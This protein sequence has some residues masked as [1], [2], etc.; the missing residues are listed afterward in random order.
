MSTNRT[1]HVRIRVK[2]NIHGFYASH[3]ELLSTYRD[4]MTIQQAEQIKDELTQLGVYRG[5]LSNGV[6]LF[7]TGN[8]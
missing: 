2:G 7:V 4:V 6:Q 5:D 8:I 1:L 3:A